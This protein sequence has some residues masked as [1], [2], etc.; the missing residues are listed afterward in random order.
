MEL[1]T[2]HLMLR[3]VQPEDADRIHDVLASD[4]E[5]VRHTGTWIWP[6]DR[7]VTARRCQDGFSAE[8]GALAAFAGDDLVGTVGLRADGDLGYMLGRAY[9]GQGYATEMGQALIDHA[10]TTGRWTTLKACVF[11]DN[12]ASGRVLE[13]LGFAETGTCLGHCA[14]R[15]GDFPIRTYAR[16]LT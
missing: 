2:K 8:G 3:P 5:V 7:A 9:W 15:Q 10:A 12:P 6:A 16:A 11:E 1:I 14:A 13:K 4:F